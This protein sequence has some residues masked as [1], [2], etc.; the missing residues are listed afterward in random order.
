MFVIMLGGLLVVTSFQL[1]LFAAKI[2]PLIVGFVMLAIVGAYLV[3]RS[4]PSLAVRFEGLAGN[5]R[6]ILFNAE[7]KSFTVFGVNPEFVVL[8]SF[9]VYLFA[10]V[11]VGPGIAMVLL[12]AF[13]QLIVVRDTWKR[14][15]ITLVTVYGT[16]WFCFI[17]LLDIRLGYGLLPL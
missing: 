15:L 11:L 8:I 7:E 5:S 13:L 2:F 17:Y 1:D 10:T 14:T 12:G 4:S 9:I 16:L 6:M 3:I